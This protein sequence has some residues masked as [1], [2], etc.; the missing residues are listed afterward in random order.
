M[1]LN[2]KGVSLVALVIT[3]IVILII[4]SI[5]FLMG[6]RNVDKAQQ[7]AF[8]TDLEGAVRDVQIYGERALQYGILDYKIEELQWDGKSDYLTKSGKVNYITNDTLGK[9]INAKHPTDEDKEKINNAPEDT[10]L[11]L[12]NNNIPNTLKGKIFIKNGKLYVDI[13]YKDEYN[14]AIE[15]YEYMSGDHK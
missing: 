5:S 15:A 9:K 10:A 8:V 4:A 11:F 6:F 7:A 3:I 2:N 13:G 1:R 12:F 14:W